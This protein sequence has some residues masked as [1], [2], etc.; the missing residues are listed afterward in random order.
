MGTLRRTG[1][2]CWRMFLAVRRGFAALRSCD[3]NQPCQNVAFLRRT[4]CR[5]SRAARCR[6][7]QTGNIPGTCGRR[8]TAPE[9][10]F[11]R[12]SVGSCC[13]ATDRMLHHLRAQPDLAAR[14]T[15]G[16]A[17]NA[18]T[19]TRSR[20]K[21]RAPPFHRP[22]TS[23]PSTMRASGRGCRQQAATPGV[24]S[25]TEAAQL[26]TGGLVV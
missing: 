6:A 19:R 20:T 1:P 24:A 5:R 17:R 8:P 4:K 10:V 14:R 21:P 23:A 18:R 13:T 26:K 15:A 22:P 16:G 3:A 25:P 7:A 2:I 9:H 11:R 12:W